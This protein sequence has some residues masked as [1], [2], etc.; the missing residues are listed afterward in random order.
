VNLPMTKVNWLLPAS[1]SLKVAFA[2][3]CGCGS[4]NPVSGSIFSDSGVCF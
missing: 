2:D 1:S 3:V 4:P